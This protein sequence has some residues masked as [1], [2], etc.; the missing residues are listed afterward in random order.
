MDSFL[1]LTELGKV[2]FDQPV[3]YA[4]SDRSSKPEVDVEQYLEGL[5]RSTADIIQWR[6]KDLAGQEIGRAHV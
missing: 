1:K 2:K 3:R 4:I 6:E 5:F